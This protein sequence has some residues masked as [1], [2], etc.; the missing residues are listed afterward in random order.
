M[1]VMQRL[2][3][4]G[5]LGWTGLLDRRTHLEQLPVYAAALAVAL[6]PTLPP[7]DTLSNP[8]GTRVLYWRRTTVNG[9]VLVPIRLQNPRQWTHQAITALTVKAVEELSRQLAQRGTLWP[10][11]DGPV[12]LRV[13]VGPAPAGGNTVMIFAGGREVAS[14]YLP[15][16]TEP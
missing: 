10:A 4:V 9:G 8:S 7:G 2:V 6:A 12:E 13:L 16:K 3:L 1:N 11:G 14:F 15:E 5:L